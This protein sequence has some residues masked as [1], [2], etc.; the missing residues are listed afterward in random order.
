MKTYNDLMQAVHILV[1]TRI[2][3]SAD[4]GMALI[5]PAWQIIRHAEVYLLK[6]ANTAMRG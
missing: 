2:A 4:D 5:S 6:Q 1:A 3:I